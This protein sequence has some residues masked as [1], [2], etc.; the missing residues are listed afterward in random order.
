[1]RNRPDTVMFFCAGRGTRM[2]HLTMDM[3]KPMLEVAGQP[4]IDHALTQFGPMR[5]RLANLHY[6]PA[7]LQ[8]HLA[9][10]GVDTVVERDLLETGGGLKNA[11]ELLGAE[12]VM[13]M[14]TDAVWIGPRASDVVLAQWDPDRM[15][16]LLLVVPKARAHGHLGAGDFE[17]DDDGVINR[18]RDFIYTGLQII[19][20]PPVREVA[21]PVFS[22]NTVWNNL[23]AKGRLFG[24][25]YEGAWCDVGHPDG[26]E[27]ATEALTEAAHVRA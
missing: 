18:G 27:I 21:E 4:L 11:D 3:P 23:H 13:T 24:A 16:A 9:D 26:I 15:D 7:P 14:N 22:M 2:K 25:V 20:M 1:M 10:T 17:L 12:T 19:K 5:K 6:C 8:A